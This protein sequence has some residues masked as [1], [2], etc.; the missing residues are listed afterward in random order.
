MTFGV[1]KVERSVT[2][3]C[4]G[5]SFTHVCLSI[6]FEDVLREDDGSLKP[7]VQNRR[8]IVEKSKYSILKEY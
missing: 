8:T 7:K 3:I 1:V 2:T 4:I 5:F 6:H